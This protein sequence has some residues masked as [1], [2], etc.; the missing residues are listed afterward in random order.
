MELWYAP[1]SPFA[2][3]VRVAAHE[4]GLA[5]RLRLIEVDPWSDARLRDLNPLAKVP[6]LVL[7]GGEAVWES[8]LIVERLADICGDRALAPPAGPARWE[9]LSLQALADGASTAAG[10]LYAD[11]RRGPGQRSEAML[12][13]F[14]AA[15]DATLRRLETSELTERFTIGEISVAVLL[16]YLDFRGLCGGWRETHPGLAAWLSRMR[17]RESLAATEHPATDVAKGR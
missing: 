7:D 5:E 15:I 13:R 1:T 6:T 11:E 9:A 10:R 12:A 2:R 17:A 4:L 8:S 3:K 14:R 16:G